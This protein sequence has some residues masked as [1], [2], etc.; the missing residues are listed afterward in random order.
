MGKK[1]ERSHNC[2]L[3]EHKR[4]IVE[5]FRHTPCFLA[6]VRKCEHALDAVPQMFPCGWAAVLEL[7]GCGEPNAHHTIAVFR[8]AVRLRKTMVS[9]THRQRRH[10]TCLSD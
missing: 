3:P 2:G 6:M 10:K 7:Y 1:W 9:S 5:A 4:P 8:S